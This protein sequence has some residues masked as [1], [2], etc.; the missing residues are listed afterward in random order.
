MLLIYQK[1][2]HFKTFFSKINFLKKTKND[3]WRIFSVKRWALCDINLEV[4]F[5][6]LYRSR[7]I[8]KLLYFIKGKTVSKLTPLEPL[9]SM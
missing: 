8:F 9:I 4:Q 7:A 2:V 6:K 1:S 5:F 3:K